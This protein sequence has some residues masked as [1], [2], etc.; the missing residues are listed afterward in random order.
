VE[1]EQFKE[2]EAAFN[3]LVQIMK[4]RVASAARDSAEE[5][6]E[7][8]EA[9]IL[10]VGFIP[11]I[12]ELALTEQI[13]ALTYKYESPQEALAAVKGEGFAI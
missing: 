1:S 7:L 5:F 6:R 10:Q 4:A 9:D 2:D 13:T 12:L 11:I 8:L 3:E